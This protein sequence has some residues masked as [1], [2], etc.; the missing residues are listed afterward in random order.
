MSETNLG[1]NITARSSA[2]AEVRGLQGAI[3]DLER[4]ISITSAR[5]GAGGAALISQL[6]VEIGKVREKIAALQAEAAATNTVTAAIREQGSAASVV[7]RTLADS[8]S[9]MGGMQIDRP[10][11][12]AAESA[13]VLQTALNAAADA[14]GRLRDS[15]NQTE[16]A[17]SRSAALVK[18]ELSG[19]QFFSMFNRQLGIGQPA[20]RRDM[21]MF[22]GP[23]PAVGYSRDT[24]AAADYEQSSRKGA[25][26]RDAAAAK[27]AGRKAAQEY[28]DAYVAARDANL[29]RNAAQSNTR[30]AADYE[31][32]DRDA[33]AAKARRDAE[34]ENAQRDAAA[35]R[36]ARSGAGIA[37]AYGPQSAASAAA[38]AAA[39][40]ADAAA[41]NMAGAEAAAQAKLRQAAAVRAVEAAERAARLAGADE[42]AVSAAGS[43]AATAAL[44]VRITEEENLGRVQVHNTRRSGLSGAARHIVPL[45][46]EAARGQRGQ[47]V[48]T[49]GA[50]AR[51]A[52][53]GVGSL[54]TSMGAL[55]AV[56][57][58]VALVHGAADMGKWATSTQAAAAAAGMA[59]APYSQ[60]QG[61]LRLTGESSESADT[62]LKYLAETLNKALVDPASMAATAFHNLGVSQEQLVS[63]GG[64]VETVLKLVADAFTQT[65]DGAAK[66]ANLQ[67]LF[68]RSVEKLIPLLQKGGAGIAEAQEHAKSLGLTLNETTASGLTKVGEKADNLVATIKGSAINAFTGWAGAIG[69]VIDKLSALVSALGTVLNFTGQVVSK[70]TDIVVGGAKAVANTVMTR[71]RA[72]FKANHPELSIPE[73]GL[74]EFGNVPSTAAANIP[75]QPVP[76]LVA[77]PTASELTALRVAQAR[78]SGASSGDDPRGA[79]LNALQGEI[80]VLQSQVNE[81]SSKP[82]D[83]VRLQTQLANKQAELSEA[84]LAERKAQEAEA[85]RHEP[86]AAEMLRHDVDVAGAGAKGGAS[87]SAEAR[88]AATTAQL[89]VLQDRLAKGQ[90][91]PGQNIDA[92]QRLELETEIAQKQSALRS[93]QLSGSGAAGKQE[94]R[95][96]VAEGKLKIAEA[97][98]NAKAIAAVYDE[99]LAHLVAS[100]S[101]TAAQIATIEREKVQAVTKA[102]LDALREGAKHEEQENRLGNANRELGQIASGKFK[103]SGQ[104]QGPAQDFARS[105]SAVGEAERVETN[106][107][108][109]VSALSQA[110]DSAN[111][112]TSARKAAEDEIL[113][114]TLQAKTQE[115]A[116]YKEAGN[117]AVEGAKK[118]MEPIKNLFDSIGTQFDAFSASILKSL[119]APQTEVVKRG[120]SSQTISEQ[121]P[122]MQK[123]VTQLF[124]GIAGDLGKTVQSA[125]SKTIANSLSGGL[126]NSVSDLLS[127]W[128]SKGLGSLIGSTAGSALG[129]VAGS[130]AGSVAGGATGAAGSVAAAATT[131]AAITASTAT[132]AAAVTASAATNVAATTAG[133]AAVV[134]AITAA[135]VTEDALLVANAVKP[136]IAGFSYSGGGIVPSA[137]GGMVVGGSPSSGG[138]L[139]VLHEKEMV[140]PAP[141]STGLQKMISQGGPN[142]GGNSA[143]LNYAP[144]INNGFKGRQGSGMSR[145]DFTQ[146]MASHSGAMF[147]EAR[148]MVRNGWRPA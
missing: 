69:L 8:A 95:D 34:F 42:A 45:F 120:L 20:P 50:A 112:G 122:Q 108:A 15:V 97:Q 121:K 6:Q 43:A 60:L 4:E 64:N 74:S 94:T 27:E 67:E 141:I 72:Q 85:K 92:R 114:V 31:N 54:A 128:L 101:A 75:K 33:I 113:A 23:V 41:A 102:T 26:A 115:I 107:R 44:R 147:G 105:S 125:L 62:T 46:D 78:A 5:Q 71:A 79:R 111:P 12:S 140:L 61:A 37:A 133:S 40:G 126:S 104:Q 70:G 106:M 47:M 99:M 21:G 88:I 68:G 53:L 103:F 96:F 98:G 82:A 35:Q 123:A 90:I 117:A 48:G 63:S 136:S 132:L 9:R 81:N 17:I 139:S 116:L 56:M 49:L 32:R 86:T 76:N 129:N 19:Q 146:M 87:G 66:A 25:E 84:K 38:R 124:T 13:R 144:T 7:F 119:I 10:I 110:R 59:L 73:E 30:S 80:D 52:G 138:K 2:T 65:E 55:V 143:A 93:E 145:S 3:K 24:R 18:R 130:A 131:T 36:Y 28:A 127:S 14:D 51:D 11:K 137:A 109:E 77:Q 135:S 16:A 83:S 22:G 89:Q 91:V 148:N 118:L 134:A 39:G 57:G 29:S 142:G 1:I 100:H 58:T